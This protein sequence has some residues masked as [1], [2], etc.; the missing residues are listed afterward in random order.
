MSVLTFV[1]LWLCTSSVL[2]F[3]RGLKG[4]DIKYVRVYDFERKTK[5]TLQKDH[6][7]EIQPPPPLKT[8]ECAMK[9][10]QMASLSNSRWQTVKNVQIDPRTMEKGTK[11]LKVP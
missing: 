11:K 5:S 2:L 10:L 6:R 9:P 4:Y 3:L 7:L 8:R 1:Q